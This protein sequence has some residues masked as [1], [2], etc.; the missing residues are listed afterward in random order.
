MNVGPVYRRWLTKL[1]TDIS[2]RVIIN[3]YVSRPFGLGRRVRQGCPLSPILYVLVAESLSSFI[4][5][6]P[7]VSGLTIGGDEVTISQYADDITIVVTDNAFQRGRRVPQPSRGSGARLNRAKSEGLWVGP[8]TARTDTPLGIVWH[9][10]S[11]KCLGVWIGYSSNV[12]ARN[13]RDATDKFDRVLQRWSG[14][15][16][17]FAGRSTVVK[18][19]AAAKLWHVA[20]VVPPPPNV[21]ADIVRKSWS[22]IWHNMRTLVRRPVCTLP[23]TAGGLGALDFDLKVAS[24]HIQW[25][26][27]LPLDDPS[28]WRLFA[29]F[30]LE[31]VSLP[32]G[33]WEEILN[34]LNVP[35]SGIPTFYVAIMKQ[36]YRFRCGVLSSIVSRRS[37]CSALLGESG[38]CRSHG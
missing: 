18:S 27:R 28:K 3:G 6:S 1:Y 34:G 20:H 5:A 10:N 12:C 24:L 26:G 23:T 35:V 11:I 22:F 8:W 16:L 17:S 14:R 31:R 33:G 4:G 2:G 15:A 29:R 7:T 36:Y 30:W 38:D 9:T 19:F 21:V 25:M 13:W 37:R 32:F